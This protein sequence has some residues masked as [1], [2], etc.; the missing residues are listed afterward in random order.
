MVTAVGPGTSQITVS[1]GNVT[2]A[3]RLDVMPLP[4]VLVSLSIGK[5]TT[6]QAGTAKQF[7]AV[8][9]YSDDHTENVTSSAVW[10]TSLDFQV[11]VDSGGMVHAVRR[12]SPQITASYQGFFGTVTVT[13]VGTPRS[14]LPPIS[15]QG[16]DLVMSWRSGD[17][18]ILR[19]ANGVA[20]VWAPAGIKR[21][22]LDSVV[23]VWKALTN[24]VLI[25]TVIAD[26]AMAQF[27]YYLDPTI[28][29]EVCGFGYP[30]T[31]WSRYNVITGGQMEIRPGGCVT[32]SILAHEF[33][34]AIGVGHTP[35]IGFTPESGVD[36]MAPA[37]VVLQ[38]SPLLVEV[39]R[40]LYSVPSGTIPI[41]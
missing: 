3:L 5:D 24:G 22:L 4:V 12:G 14:Q 18:S 33:G 17:G 15:Q 34:H 29:G 13:V 26:S 7:A 36:F 2:G 39:V 31:S 35:Q 23:V 40:W 1:F 6:M 27:R 32:A 25:P 30:G 11:V 37:P 38:T 19:A 28:T 20:T 41:G 8:A 16:W 9:K 10:T 21:V